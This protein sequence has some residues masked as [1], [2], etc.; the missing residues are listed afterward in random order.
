[1]IPFRGEYVKCHV[2]VLMVAF[3]TGSCRVRGVVLEGNENWPTGQTFGGHN[4]ALTEEL[5]AIVIGGK[6]ATEEGRP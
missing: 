4:I 5:H 3:T 1:M 2:E 6:Y